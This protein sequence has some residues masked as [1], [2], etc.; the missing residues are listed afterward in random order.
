MFKNHVHD[1]VTSSREVLETEVDYAKRKFKFH[2]ELFSKSL[3]EAWDDRVLTI[4]LMMDQRVRH[5]FLRA[6]KRRQKKMIEHMCGFMVMYHPTTGE[7]A[8]RTQRH[9][10]PYISRKIEFV[11]EFFPTTIYD[12]EKFR[13]Y[14]SPKEGDLTLC[15]HFNDPKRKPEIIP[16]T[17]DE[18]NR[19]L[20]DEH[21]QACSEIPLEPKT[22]KE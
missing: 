12:P 1:P 18:V 15:M 5:N 7:I 10:G 3:K 13:E 6:S 19:I 9:N 22:A 17:M 20:G 8:P 14:Y 2:R 21:T 16:Y 11:E 4:S